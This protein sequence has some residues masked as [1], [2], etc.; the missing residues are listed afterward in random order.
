MNRVY[1]VLFAVGLCLSTPGYAHS[2]TKDKMLVT[3]AGQ[4]H[5]LLTAHLSKEGNELDIFFETAD[6][7]AAPVALMTGG[8]TLR[9]VLNRGK[10]QELNF[11][12]APAEERPAGE[13]AGTCSHFVAKAPWMKRSD[14]LKVDGTV[15]ASGFDFKVAWR[16]FVPE[17]Y[18][19]HVE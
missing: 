11:T 3:D 10:A 15:T 13:K 5:A 12:C 19:H 6:K 9:A 1:F 16:N 7:V 18:A 8:F 14:N 4:Y 17:R 2:H